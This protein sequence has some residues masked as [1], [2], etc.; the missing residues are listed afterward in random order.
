MRV[1]ENGSFL[2]DNF[3]REKKKLRQNYAKCA[4]SRGSRAKAFEYAIE[5]VQ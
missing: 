5:S 4:S 1:Q 3:I 2:R